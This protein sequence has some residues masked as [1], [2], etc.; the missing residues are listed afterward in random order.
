LNIAE[1]RPREQGYE[2]LCKAQSSPEL[3]DDEQVGAVL[4]RV[5]EDG[6]TRDTVLQP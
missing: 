3:G 4:I 2:A 5:V 1:F 6:H